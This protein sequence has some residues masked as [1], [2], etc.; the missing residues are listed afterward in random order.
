MRDIQGQS[1]ICQN[2]DARKTFRCTGCE[3]SW[4]AYV[5]GE[6]K[7]IHGKIMRLL[8]TSSRPE[9]TTAFLRC[10]QY[11]DRLLRPLWHRGV[12]GININAL[13]GQLFGQL[14]KGSWLVRKLELFDCPFGVGNCACSRNFFA[15]LMSSTTNCAKP[16]EPAVPTSRRAEMFT[17]ASARIH[18]TRSNAPG[19]FSSEIVSCLTLA[20]C[21]P[22]FTAGA[23]YIAS[24]IV[25]GMDANGKR[26]YGW[27]LKL[28]P[29]WAQDSADMLSTKA[30]G[31]H[32]GRRMFGW[33]KLKETS[34]GRAQLLLREQPL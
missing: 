32:H 30:F 3:Q 31:T 7:E 5:T 14:C 8:I 26:V 6:P 22:S 10:S 33:E 18:A 9:F 13:L 28:T 29:D 21:S 27:G 25:L 4:A 23:V 12:S 24:R 2:E 11:N 1:C 34:V 20:I 19:W 15:F 17:L 16:W